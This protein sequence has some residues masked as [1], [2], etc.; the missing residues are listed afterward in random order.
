MQFIT[1]TETDKIAW[2]K[3]VVKHKGS[4]FSNSKYLDST[5]DKWL[6]LYND[7]QTAGMACPFTTKFGQPILYAPFFHRYIEWIGSTP[8][9]KTIITELQTQFRVATAHV[10]GV[11]PDMKERHYQYIESN[12]LNLNQQAKRSVKKAI[13][14]QVIEKIAIDPLLQL[15]EKEL[16]SKIASMNSETSQTL[17]KL[18]DSF[19][20]SGLIQLNL[21]KNDR[22]KGGI[23]L[24]ENETTVLYLKGTVENDSKQNGGMYAL[25]LFGIQ[26]ATSKNK[27]FDFGGSSVEN[28]RRFN[29]HFG[30]KDAV[31]SHLQWN[32]APFWWTVLRKIKHAWSKK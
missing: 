20:S 28:V 8:N 2:N 9:W 21:M 15:I 23:W 17:R 16:S 7:D 22:W 14:F 3:L 27:R 26:Y 6:I 5:A 18:V 31:Y 12:E 4:L 24:L 10:N 11:I 29:L 1:P 32:K 19:A 25:M 30:A 13:D